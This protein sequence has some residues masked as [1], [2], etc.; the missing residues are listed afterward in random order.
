VV[1]EVP[2]K[3]G[4]PLSGIRRL[5]GAPAFL[6]LYLELV[7]TMLAVAVD[8]GAM[9]NLVWKEMVLEVQA[10]AEAVP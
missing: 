6:L 4:I 8:G 10:E 7:L 5:M 1:A 9:K 3:P 2:V